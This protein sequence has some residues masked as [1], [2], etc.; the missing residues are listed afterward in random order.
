MPTYKYRSRAPKCR[1]CRDGYEIFE[2]IHLEPQACCPLC[3]SAVYRV[4]QRPKWNI[5]HSLKGDMREYRED[6]ARFSRD[7]EAFCDGPTA[8]KK[9]IDKRKRQGW[10]EGPSYQECYDSNV[11]SATDQGDPDEQKRI[12]VEAYEEARAEGFS[13]NSPD[14]KDFMD[15]LTENE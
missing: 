2:S 13:M 15:D 8:V 9:L 7:P 10:T 5:R 1:E 6:L 14:V 3:F 12:Q 11:A 4:I